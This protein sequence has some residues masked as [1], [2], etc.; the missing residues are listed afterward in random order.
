MRKKPGLQ[1]L[2]VVLFLSSVV[3]LPT[4]LSSAPERSPGF[5]TAGGTNPGPELTWDCGTIDA[6]LLTRLASVKTQCPLAL[7]GG[8]AFETDSIKGDTLLAAFN[9]EDAMVA[10]HSGIDANSA[11]SSFGGTIDHV[12]Q[13]ED[14][15]HWGLWRSGA[16]ETLPSK[17]RYTV[18]ESAAVPYI[19]GISAHYVAARDRVAGQLK[20]LSDLPDDVV[21][22]YTLAGETGV[23]SGKDFQG[24]FVPVG[25]VEAANG[26]IDF[27]NRTGQIDLTIEVR[28]T[29]ATIHL[30]LK[31]RNRILG[32]SA[33]AESVGT[34]CR[35]P[36][37][38]CPSANAQF[39]GRDG[40]YLGIAFRYEHN[41]VLPEAASVAA[42]LNNVF[43][44]GAVVLQKN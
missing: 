33:G 14:V 42:R 7:I 38:S 32:F 13:Q 29:T 28:G 21:A 44:N 26:T 30:P 19:V 34:P 31:P 20:R 41:A 36:A 23:V 35:G 27:K 5:S 25:R 17:H 18:D 11:T 9:K 10:V 16:I 22:I 43:A 24:N 4:Q 15:I 8:A 12:G 39:Y 3:W 40:Q 37:D 1:I 2:F 6:A